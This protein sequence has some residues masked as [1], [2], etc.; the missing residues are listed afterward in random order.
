MNAKG[1]TFRSTV[2]KGTIGRTNVSVDLV[3]IDL[4]SRGR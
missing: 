4:G 1:W 3:S 2:K